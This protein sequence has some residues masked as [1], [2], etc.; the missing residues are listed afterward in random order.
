MKK[1]RKR[2]E[3]KR[4]KGEKGREREKVVWQKKSF[5]FTIT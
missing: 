2:K 1:K 5:S 3:G 4:R